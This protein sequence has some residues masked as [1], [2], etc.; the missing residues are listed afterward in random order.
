MHIIVCL[1][2]RGGMSFFGR[3][4]SMDRA[5]REKAVALAGGGRLWMSPYSAGQFSDHPEHIIADEA[6]LSKAPE[7]AWCFAELENIE[8]CADRIQQI[9]VFHWNRLYP[10]D[11][12]F[13]EEL[14]KGRKLLCREDFAGYSHE[15][16]TLEVFDL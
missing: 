15:Q 12:R 1:D 3:R 8:A 7:N 4:Q 2:D 11:R 9:A 6:F 10:S 14:L 13:P 16:I 5:L